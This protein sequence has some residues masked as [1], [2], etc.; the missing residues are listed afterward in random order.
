MKYFLLSLVVFIIGC[1][2]GR[3]H[4]YSAES[5]RHGPS[6]FHSVEEAREW[7]DR[8]EYDS[9]GTVNGRKIDKLQKQKAS[10]SPFALTGEGHPGYRV[11]PSMCLDMMTAQIKPCI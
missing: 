7:N 10:E 4:V 3:D 2:D 9:Y 6:V 8:C 1:D 11:A 5:C